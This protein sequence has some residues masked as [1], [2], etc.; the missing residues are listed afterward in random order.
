MTVDL[1]K[2]HG[3]RGHAGGF[4]AQQAARKG[5]ENRCRYALVGDIADHNAQAIFL[6]SDQVVQVA[7]HGP[8]RAHHHAQV[9][10]WNHRKGVRQDAFLNLM[11]HLKL[12]LQSFLF[13]DLHLRC[14]QFGIGGGQ[15]TVFFLQALNDRIVGVTK[16]QAE[17]PGDFKGQVRLAVKQGAKG[18]MAHLQ[19]GG[20]VLAR[21][22]AD[23]RLSRSNMLISPRKLPGPQSCSSR[24]SAVP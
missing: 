4:G 7:A 2:H 13:D 1:A 15:L 23:L 18:G 9:N 3:R 16:A 11:G 22:V 20:G 6:Q 8:C 14:L 21:T 5:H 12:T 19:Q 24:S 10:T 17:L